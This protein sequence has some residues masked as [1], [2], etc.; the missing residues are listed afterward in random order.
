M[1]NQG[2]WDWKKIWLEM[3]AGTGPTEFVLPMKRFHLILAGQGEPL[4]KSCV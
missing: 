4:K 3:E 1:A 2:L